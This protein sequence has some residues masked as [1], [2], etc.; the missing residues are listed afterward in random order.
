VNTSRYN[1][2][3][4]VDGR[5]I[6]AYNCLSGALA[7]L[8]AEEFAGLQAYCENPDDGVFEARGLEALRDG[9]KSGGFLIPD[10][11]DERESMRA[12]HTAIKVQRRRAI[13]LT[14]VPT[15]DCNFRC[16]YCFSYARR[17]RMSAEVQEALLRF[18]EERLPEVDAL[19]T[20]W[21]G[22]EPTL[23]L[24]LIEGLSGRLRD[25]C[26]RHKVEVQGCG[27][28]TN[29]YLLTAKVA[30]RLKS[31]GITD[32]Q[33]TLDGDRETHNARRPL[34]HSGSGTFDRILENVAATR[35]IL[36]IQIRINVDRDNAGTAIAALD[37]LAERGLQGTPAYFGHVQAFTDAC[38][39]AAS[40]CLSDAE[41][42][43]LNMELTRQALARGFTALRYPQPLL[44]G[45]CGAEHERGYLIAPD[46]LLFKCWAEAS[47]GVEHSVGSVFGGEV[48]PVQQANLRC[49]L[50]WDALADPECGECPVLPICMGGCPYLRVHGPPGSNCST[51]RHSLLETLAL[52]YKV[53][54]LM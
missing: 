22:G 3:F 38:A 34:R 14:I 8:S 15:L 20:T 46:G 39:G 40:T 18:V 44:G 50:D 2:F 4:R 10:E 35:G 17:E 33:V 26:E 54:Q 24:G 51:W 6:L 41:F 13:G 11:L 42:A 21:Y 28:V 9:L 49:Y 29:G 43:Q 30:K 53:R 7:R 23:C 52:R 48:T 25:L 36:D 32:A 1:S 16:S 37:A 12:L 45:V 19:S 27:V 31:A 47:L 5:D